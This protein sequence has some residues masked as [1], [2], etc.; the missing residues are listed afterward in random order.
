MISL[1]DYHGFADRRVESQLYGVL[2][3]RFLSTP[4]ECDRVLG[5]L[6]ADLLPG[7]ADVRVLDVGCG[8]GQAIRHLGERFEWWF[9]GIDLRPEAIRE[10]TVALPG[11][12]LHATDLFEYGTTVVDVIVC[13]SVTYSFT[14]EQ[15]SDTLHRFRSWLQPGGIVV[16]FDMFT[17][18]EQRLQVVEC[19]LHHPDG[20]LLMVRPYSQLREVAS[21]TGLEVL[22]IRPFRYSGGEHWTDPHDLRSYHEGGFT[23]RGCFNQTQAHAVLVAV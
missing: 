16:L 1:A 7:R 11:V 13:Q 9:T 20:H 5:D 8:N 4:K 14:D 18:W 3:R 22:E 17:P 6:L 23:M 12:P 21:S 2:Q 15:F 10:A 19:S